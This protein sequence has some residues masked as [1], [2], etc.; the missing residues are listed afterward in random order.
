MAVAWEAVVPTVT[1]GD[2]LVP[3]ISA[4]AR[5]FGKLVVWR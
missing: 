1:V 2:G 4:V 3:Q 5:S